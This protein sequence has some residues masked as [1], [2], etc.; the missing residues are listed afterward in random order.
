[1]RWARGERRHDQQGSLSKS[2]GE[3]CQEKRLWSFLASFANQSLRHTSRQ[4]CSF[5]VRVVDGSITIQLFVFIFSPV[6][7]AFHV[8]RHGAPLATPLA[9]DVMLTSR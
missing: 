5:G 3:E 2:R 9:R 1:M 7:P 4:L 8:V 6:I